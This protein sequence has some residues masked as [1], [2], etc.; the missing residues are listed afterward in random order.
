[1][2]GTRSFTGPLLVLKRVAPCPTH[3]PQTGCFW[4]TNLSGVLSGR[5]TS[6]P[7]VLPTFGEISVFNGF[8]SF[9]FVVGDL[10]FKKFLYIQFNG[11]SGDKVYSTSH[12]RML[13]R[14][15]VHPSG[16]SREP[17]R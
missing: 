4:V 10:C 15:L 2:C 1:M 13:R 5:G 3:V 14:G 8:A 11:V 17:N 7:P 12:S 9:V 16:A 6:P